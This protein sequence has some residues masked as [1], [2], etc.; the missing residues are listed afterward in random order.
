MV[1][2]GR[3]GD[4]HGDGQRP[5]PHNQVG[6]I[7]ATGSQLLFDTGLKTKFLRPGLQPLLN[8]FMPRPAP[9]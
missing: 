8:G 6:G 3:D 7:V 5:A 9:A 4:F 2:G 1:N